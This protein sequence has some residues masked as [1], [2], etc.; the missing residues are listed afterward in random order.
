MHFISVTQGGN[1]PLIAL[2]SQALLIPSLHFCLYLSVLRCYHLGLDFLDLLP[3]NRISS[4]SFP[5][6]LSPFNSTSYWCH[7]NE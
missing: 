1:S 5:C 7:I 3:D 2:R 6:I 4:L